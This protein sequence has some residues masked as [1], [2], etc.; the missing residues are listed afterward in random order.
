MAPVG[1]ASSFE[2]PDTP[3]AKGDRSSE[4]QLMGYIQVCC[5]SCLEKL[6]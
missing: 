4:T 6:K 1:E 3:W 5:S 2:P